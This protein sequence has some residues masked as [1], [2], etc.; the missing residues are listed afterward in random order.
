VVKTQ[1]RATAI[2]RSLPAATQS[3][4][5][6]KQTYAS[7]PG[8]LFCQPFR[9]R[10]VV[11]A[12]HVLILGL[13]IQNRTLLKLEGKVRFFRNRLFSELSVALLW[14]ASW[15]ANSIRKHSA[16]KNSV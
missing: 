6:D 11:G 13:P 8:N 2:L 3:A 14:H 10:S 9:R 4:L 16:Q 1:A 12:F 15:L 7:F 5:P